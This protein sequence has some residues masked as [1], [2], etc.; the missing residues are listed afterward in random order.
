LNSL[1]HWWQTAVETTRKQLG[2]M[3]RRP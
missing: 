3:Q 1:G 2:D